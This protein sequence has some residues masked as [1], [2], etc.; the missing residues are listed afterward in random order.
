[1]DASKRPIGGLLLASG[2]IPIVCGSAPALSASNLHLTTTKLNF[3]S[4]H[5]LGGLSVQWIDEIAQHC[6]SSKEKKLVSI[7]R[8]PSRCLVVCR[9]TELNVAFQR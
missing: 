7:F 9:R 2:L 6:T 5:G 1:M 3:A 4:L 8:F